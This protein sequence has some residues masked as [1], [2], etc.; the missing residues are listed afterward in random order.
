MCFNMGG[1]MHEE[2]FMGKYPQQHQLPRFGFIFQNGNPQVV[3]INIFQPLKYLQNRADSTVLTVF[4]R[5]KNINF[6]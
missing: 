6:H 1:P 3:K 4:E 5:L 2:N